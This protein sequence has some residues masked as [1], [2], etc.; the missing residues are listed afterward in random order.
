[1]PKE[2]QS[3]RTDTSMKEFKL[4][5]KKNPRKHMDKVKESPQKTVINLTDIPDSSPI[6]GQSFPATPISERQQSLQ[7][8]SST[9][10]TGEKEEIVFD[11]F[12]EIKIRNEILKKNTY[13]QFWKQNATSQGILIS[14][15]DSEEGKMHMA[16][17]GAQ[18][19]EPKNP[20]DYKQNSF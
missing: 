13:A 1:M 12:W 10:V 4:K 20:V 6:G 15:F 3:R 9:N 17:L 2:Y 18:I 14:T 19:A 16:F 7:V 8:S 5:Y 11:T